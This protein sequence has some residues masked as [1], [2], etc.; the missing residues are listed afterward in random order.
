M[1]EGSGYCDCDSEIE[2]VSDA[3]TIANMVRTGTGEG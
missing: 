1:N 2:S 3:A